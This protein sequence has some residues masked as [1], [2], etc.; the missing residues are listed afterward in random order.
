MA[1]KKRQATSDNKDIKKALEDL[2]EHVT[3]L[4]T[5]PATFLEVAE[6]ISRF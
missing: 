1:P 5:E 4:K 3:V 2:T 6:E